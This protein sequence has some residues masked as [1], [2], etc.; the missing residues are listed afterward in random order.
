MKPRH[1]AALALVGWYLMFPTVHPAFI[2]PSDPKFKQGSLD[3]KAPP[4]EW[5]IAEWRCN[6][7]SNASSTEIPMCDV[8]RTSDECKAAIARIKLTNPLTGVEVKMRDDW[9][10]KAQCINTDDDQLKGWPL[11]EF[12]EVE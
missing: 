10:G 3:V 12:W 4:H 1:A 11:K 6:T 9:K 2:F 5:W 8:F 7:A